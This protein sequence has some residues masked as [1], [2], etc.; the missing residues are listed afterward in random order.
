MFS[1]EITNTNTSFQERYE[2]LQ[3]LGEG[4]YGQVFKAKDKIT[5]KTVAV[6]F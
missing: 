2:R 6:I 5:Q 4:T 3:K 1:P